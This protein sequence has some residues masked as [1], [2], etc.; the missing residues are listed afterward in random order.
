[1]VASRT[2][3]IFAVDRAMRLTDRNLL[4]GQYLALGSIWW[5]EIAYSHSLYPI[6]TSENQNLW[7]TQLII[8]FL[9]LTQKIC[10][11]MKCEVE[12]YLSGSFN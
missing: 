9:R 7:L 1:M 8:Q 5:A 11:S 4:K 10:D 3:Q 2:A 12:I 6:V